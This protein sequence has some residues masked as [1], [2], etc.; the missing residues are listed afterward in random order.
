M[1]SWNYRVFNLR[2]RI[3]RLAAFLLLGSAAAQAGTVSGI[4]HNGTNSDKA[5]AGVEILLIQLQGGMQVVANAPRRT[6][7]GAI[8]F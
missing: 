6:P 8:T 7:T 5:A 1:K 2:W 4:V 3:T